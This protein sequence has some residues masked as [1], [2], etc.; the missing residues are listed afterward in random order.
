MLPVQAL[1]VNR[2]RQPVRVVFALWMGLC[3]L[4]GWGS[5]LFPVTARGADLTD[6]EEVVDNARLTFAQFS[7]NPDLAW[8]RKNLKDARG[9][10]ILPRVLQAGYF[11]GAAL[12]SGVLLLHDERTGEWSDPAFYTVTAGSFG[13][14]IGLKRSQVVA[15]IMTKKGID[16]MIGSKFMLG[17]DLNLTV[18]PVGRGL[19]GGVTPTLTADVVAYARSE[20]AYGGISLRG[21]ILS[22]DD[23]WNE[24]YFGRPMNASEILLNASS[25]R[26]WYSAR[27]RA[28][29]TSAQMEDP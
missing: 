27:L 6:L 12:G 2:F 15:L 20:G 8:L 13:L 22:P 16:S 1:I 14:Q 19:T 23:G 17:G 9:V 18:G 10:L 25:V 26:H 28:A 29:V 11:V 4:T 7:G 24:L 3:L 21:L 5:L